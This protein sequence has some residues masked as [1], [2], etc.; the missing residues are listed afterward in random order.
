MARKSSLPSIMDESDKIRSGKIFSGTVTCK[1]VES[2]VGKDGRQHEALS[3]STFSQTSIFFVIFEIS[4]IRQF[5]SK[6]I[7][8]RVKI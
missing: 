6:E 5:F 8:E 2:S 4:W 3:T 7:V 1:F